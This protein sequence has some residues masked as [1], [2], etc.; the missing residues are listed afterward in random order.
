[1]KKTIIAIAITSMI[2]AGS[3]F[4]SCKSPAQKEED[5]Q[6]K[7]Q[8]AKQD[9]KDA[10]TDANTQAVKVATAEEWTA[11]KTE[12]ELKIRDNDVRIAELKVKMNKPGKVLDG[13]YEKRILALEKQNKDLQV[14]IN[15]YDNNRSD[16]ELF[17]RE[18][19]HDMDELGQALKDLTVKNTK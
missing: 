17:K 5:A 10:Q 14:R 16:W 7:V 3:V 12:S 4:T 18:F 1:M 2:I 6:A 15:T 9:L 19:N 13:I 8:D 11:F